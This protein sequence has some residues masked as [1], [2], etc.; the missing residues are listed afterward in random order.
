MLTY[1][2]ECDNASG[3]FF[4]FMSGDLVWQERDGR[5]R[6]AGRAAAACHVVKVQA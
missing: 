3:Y 5:L 1:V 6:F 2:E 4:F